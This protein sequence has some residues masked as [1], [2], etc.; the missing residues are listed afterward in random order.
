MAALALAA[1]LLEMCAGNLV[2]R[3]KHRHGNDTPVGA[4]GAGG[5]APGPS[6]PATMHV[7]PSDSA[8]QTGHVGNHP[9]RSELY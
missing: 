7:E 3:Q 1:A 8:C 9:S 6:H 5:G 2:S 4:V